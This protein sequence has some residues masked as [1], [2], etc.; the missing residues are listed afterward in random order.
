MVVLA[1]IMSNANLPEKYEY[2]FTYVIFLDLF[3]FEKND[4]FQIILPGIN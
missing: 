3:N 4:S 2:D 1:S